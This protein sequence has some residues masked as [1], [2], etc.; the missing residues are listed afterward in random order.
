MR[1]DYLSADILLFRGDSLAALATAF[2]DGERVLLVDALASQYDAIDL[3]DYL[4]GT[5]GKQVTTIV[6]TDAR[7]AHAAA[8]ALFPDAQL[9]HP[10][11]APAQLQWGRHTL[12]LQQR[13]DGLY[14]D[15]PSADLQFV[16]DSIVG[17]IA[18]LGPLSPEQAD[19]K[20]VRLL[21][22]GRTRIVPRHTAAVCN[23]AL[24]NARAYLSRLGARV[25]DLRTRLPDSEAAAAIA[26]LPLDELLGKGDFAT[27]LE[28][29]WH[30]DN[31]RRI[32][33]RGLFAAAPRQNIAAA[34]R[35]RAQTCCETVGTVLLA[36]LGRLAERGI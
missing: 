19:D 12:A 7:G 8:A 28:R 30:A 36:M 17:N 23:R 13:D 21:D 5:L 14:V 29:H 3:R 18:V 26:R 2:I 25:S 31:L 32:A 4:E 6:L 27:P 16:G 9:V 34:A 1:I 33:E 22:Q 20:L 35:R 10:H 24:G 11:H 15:V